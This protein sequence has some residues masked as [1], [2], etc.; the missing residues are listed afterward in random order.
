LRRITTLD[1]GSARRLRAATTSHTRTKKICSSRA[2]CR[3]EWIS[4]VATSTPP[5]VTGIAISAPFSGSSTA[6]TGFPLDAALAEG[7]SV[8]SCR[9]S[10]ASPSHG[11]RSRPAA[12]EGCAR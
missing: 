1:A 11:P 9:A 3:R 8:A 5:T 12:R 4:I 2:K 7:P 6:M 10:A